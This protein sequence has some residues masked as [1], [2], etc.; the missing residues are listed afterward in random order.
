MATRNVTQN[1]TAGDFLGFGQWCCQ[2]DLC[3]DAKNTVM[4]NIV[5]MSLVVGLVIMIW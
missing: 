1:C 4:T 2:T 3:N 5:L